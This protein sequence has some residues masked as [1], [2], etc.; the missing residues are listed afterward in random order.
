[1]PRRFLPVIPIVLQ[2]LL[3]AGAQ[4]SAGQEPQ[5]ERTWKDDTGRFEIVARYEGSDGTNVTLKKADGALVRVPLLR[6][7]AEDRK[8]IE[9]LTASNPFVTVANPPRE[10]EEAVVRVLFRM[11]DGSEVTTAGLVF[12][13]DDKRAYVLTSS[14][15]PIGHLVRM[16]PASVTIVR[17]AAGEPRHVAAEMVTMP[18]RDGNCIVG[19]PLADLPGS[20]Q[21]ASP[22]DIREGTPV[23]IS[24]YDI[25]KGPQES[26]YARVRASATI[27]KVFRTG[28]NEILKW[29]IDGPDLAK[30]RFG[31]ASLPDGKVVGPLQ[32]EPAAKNHWA[33][34]ITTT[35]GLQYAKQP[36]LLKV[37][38]EPVSGD[39]DMI[40]YGFLVSVLDPFQ[41]LKSPKL[42]ITPAHRQLGG[43]LGGFGG[44]PT[45]GAP[46]QAAPNRPKTIERDLAPGTDKDELVVKFGKER[47]EA[48]NVKL[49]IAYLEEANSG[50]NQQPQF[51]VALSGKS[52]D[53]KPLPL[54]RQ[55]PTLVSFFVP[56][57]SGFGPP[58]AS[59]T[60]PISN[61]PGL[62]GF[63]LDMP[64]P[65][66]HSRGG[67]QITSNL[68]R[69]KDQP[70]SDAASFPK[71]EAGK[72]AVEALRETESGPLK[73]TLLP[74]AGAPGSDQTARNNASGMFGFG[75][76]SGFARGATH[77][78]MVYS[79][80]G[81]WLYLVDGN[82]VLR[83][84]DASTFVEAVSLNLQQVCSGLAISRAGLVASIESARALWVLDAETLE[85]QRQ[86]PL[87]D[88]LLL[89][90]SPASDL[91]FAVTFPPERVSVGHPSQLVMLDF[92][93]GKQLHVIKSFY[94]THPQS[95]QID[96]RPIFTSHPKPTDLGQTADGKTLLFGTNKLSKFRLEGTDLVFEQAST[97]HRLHAASQF[98]L[99][100]DGKRL[101][102]R[103][104]IGNISDYFVGLFDV[105]DLSKPLSLL[106]GEIKNASLGLDPKTQNI[107]AP[108]DNPGVPGVPEVAVRIF[109]PAGGKIATGGVPDHGPWRILVHPAGERFILWSFT[110]IFAVSVHPESRSE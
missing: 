16:L 70:T 67:W 6:L 49:L 95:I 15:Q 37:D 96:D 19:A 11:P 110:R 85:V 82:Q 21:W 87:S 28:T 78:P 25:D 108:I 92:A 27:N 14:Q 81:K 22:A 17:D 3:L 9:S 46:K 50:P 31:I 101:L 13:W 32:M 26:S 1:M 63:P 88:V 99:S 89:T 54:S 51:N 102:M 97:E 5:P 65:K 47:Q 30:L 76:A 71:P 107:Y 33:T 84:L 40:R 45:R 74:F 55:G 83:K 68:T 44:M 98:V 56:Q 36:R 52:P 39:A 66:K 20:L 90:A 86:I 105:A 10:V 72:P 79:P 23:A 24:G 94:G 80:D 53:G 93:K 106:S 34:T 77:R 29:G 38:F 103:A 35:A 41:V 18:E 59:P 64:R 109:S 62:D 48:P 8:H 100:T 73:W 12:H 43:G 57:R 58:M 104:D 60:S 2:L 61:I 7:S 75:T 69:V 4:P 42:S 91:G